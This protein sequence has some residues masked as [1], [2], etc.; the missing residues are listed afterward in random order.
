MAPAHQQLSRHHLPH[1][2]ACQAN[3][4]CLPKASKNLERNLEPALRDRRRMPT[5]E[6]SEEMILVLQGDDGNLEMDKLQENG[7]TS[8]DISRVIYN[9][10]KFEDTP[11]FL[12]VMAMETHGGLDRVHEIWD[13]SKIFWFFF[14]VGSAIYNLTYLLS[15]DWPI[16]QSFTSYVVHW[17][18]RFVVSKWKSSMHQAHLLEEE[19]VESNSQLHD[20]FQNVTDPPTREVL[21]HL[22]GVIATWE[23]SWIFLKLALAGKH[24]WRFCKDESEFIQYRSIV[25]FFQ[26]LLPTFSTFSAIKLISKIHPSVMHNEYLHYISES[27]M[28]GTTAGFIAITLWFFFK[29]FICAATALGAF[30]IK[31]LAVSMKMVNSEYSVL[32]RIINIVA[33]MN[34]VIGCLVMEIVMQDRLFLFVFGGQDSMYRDDEFARKNVYECRLAKQIWTDFWERGK[35]FKAIVLLATYDHYDLQTLLLREA[36]LDD[37]MLAQRHFQRY[38]TRAAFLQR[39]EEVGEVDDE[40]EIVQTPRSQETLNDDLRGRGLSVAVSPRP[41]LELVREASENSVVST[42]SLGSRGMPVV[43]RV[44]RKFGLG[45]TDTLDG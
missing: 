30:S 39:V 6:L 28:R 40:M 29:E 16:F 45:W 13:N 7:Y 17:I 36:V 41:Q 15:V 38:D 2:G 32:V 26:R 9:M 12:N 33:L 31:M 27:D 18:K 1:K 11:D 43:S 14:L 19:A 37:S 34:Q 4:T 20:I 25:N 22:A 42:W 8:E 21:I 3:T 5:V 10:L 44:L 24:V 35:R 23:L